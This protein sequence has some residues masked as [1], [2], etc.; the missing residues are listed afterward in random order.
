M[1]LT[2][3]NKHGLPDVL[4]RAIAN[5]SYSRGE[6]DISVTQLI[7]PPYQ[8]QLMEV[9]DRIED[10]A[11]RI[12]S[13]LGTSVHHVIERAAKPTDISEERFFYK[14]GDY[15]ISGAC[16]LLADGTLY[17]FKLTSVWSFINGGKIEW[18]RQLNLLRYLA[19]Q[20]ALETNDARYLANK[21]QIVTL[22]RDFQ[23]AKAGV[24][25]YPQAAAALIEVPVWPLVDAG[26]YLHERVKAHF[27][28]QPEPCTDEERWATKEVF[29]VM[30][31]DRKS[32]I[33]LHDTREAAEQMAADKG[34]GHYIE[35]RPKTYRRC[36][37]YCSVAHACPHHNSNEGG[38]F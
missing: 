27:S 16:D 13:L 4:V 26:L 32:A 29:A 19:A 38:A 5:D 10:V 18:E 37:S 30:K 25:G 3:T 33:K 24:D 17:D 12:F 20:K 31:K 36:E 14:A 15:I 28:K 9:T 11:D 21:L 6:S 22:F 35:L 1:G 2:L 7:T 34:T 8:R 23:Q